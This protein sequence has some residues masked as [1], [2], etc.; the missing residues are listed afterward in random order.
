MSGSVLAAAISVQ[1]ERFCCLQNV[2]A[3]R[4]AHG[5]S[6]QWVLVD[7]STGACS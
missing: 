1:A 5:A 2:Q 7:L 6:D 3:M 4:G